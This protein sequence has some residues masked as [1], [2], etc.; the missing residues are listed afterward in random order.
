MRMNWK[1]HPAVKGGRQ[2]RILTT[3]TTTALL[4]HWTFRVTPA[5]LCNSSRNSTIKRPRRRWK[6]TTTT[7]TTTK[8]SL[9]EGRP[10]RPRHHA[11]SQRVV[12]PTTTTTTA[13]PVVSAASRLYVQD[14]FVAVSSSG[15]SD[16]G[17][18]DEESTASSAVQQARDNAVEP[19]ER[20]HP[21]VATNDVVGSGGSSDDAA[22]TQPP[23]E[24]PRRRPG[25]LRHR[26]TS[27]GGTAAA[28]VAATITH[29]DVAATIQSVCGI[30]RTHIVQGWERQKLRQ[31][32]R[33]TLEPLLVC[34]FR[35]EGKNGNHHHHNNNSENEVPKMVASNSTSIPSLQ[36]IVSFYNA[37]YLA[38]K[39]QEDTILLSL[40]YLE[41]LI[42]CTN[43][44]LVPTPDNW[45]SLLF[46][47]MILASKVS[48]D[49][50]CWNVDFSDISQARGMS[51]LFSLERIN[52]LEVALLTSLKFNVRVSASE[53][54]KY[55]FLI[56]A[57]MTRAGGKF[58]PS[59]KKAVPPRRQPPEG[60]KLSPASQF[61]GSSHKKQMSDQPGN[62]NNNGSSTPNNKQ[63][64][65]SADWNMFSSVLQAIEVPSLSSLVARTSQ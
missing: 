48:D 24:Q 28:A 47:C 43:G 60:A 18:D 21:T 52:E 53:Y 3:T 29:P 8:S 9:R 19:K 42:K 22:S 13:G 39:M 20:K 14:G 62:N 30:Y 12:V 7:T 65:F 59:P 36:D 55:Y 11:R 41:R 15:S 17:T 40:I 2:N 50:S 35:D 51:H 10:P 4:P 33:R 31:Y 25:H 38:S 49:F 44:T 27:E 61:F 45:R 58:F 32:R 26:N 34:L 23:S 54:A 1:T 56:R 64:S 6:T 57:M 46:S 37:Y 16:S 63:R 5:P